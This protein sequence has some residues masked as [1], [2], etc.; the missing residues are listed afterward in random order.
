MQ[1]IVTPGSI[2]GLLAAQAQL[3]EDVHAAGQLRQGKAPSLTSML[4]GTALLEIARP[5][6]SKLLP[7]HFV[8]AVTPTR[9]VAFKAWGGSGEDSSDYTL[10]VRPGVAAEFPRTAVALRDLADGPR[11]VG[12]T[13]HVG[14]ERIPVFRP[15]MTGGGDPDTDHLLAV[16]GA[17]A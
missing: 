4:L 16:L 6:R 9:V 3:G 13:L 7:R 15:N 11:S 12:G 2:P 5:R 17:V 8:L 14:D 1:T 10:N